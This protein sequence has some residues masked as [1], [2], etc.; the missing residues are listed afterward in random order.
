MN[1]PILQVEKLTKRFGGHATLMRAA[2]DARARLPVFEPEAPA[3]AGLTR[4]V[5][6]AFD[7]RHILNPGRMF[8][9]C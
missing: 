1:A 9:D 5:K 8:E 7:G 2:R 6:A 3:R 4:A